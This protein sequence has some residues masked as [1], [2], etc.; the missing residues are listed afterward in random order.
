L[1]LDRRLLTSWFTSAFCGCGR[2]GEINTL[3]ASAA[4]GGQNLHL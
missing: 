4:W 1:N 2:G 3:H